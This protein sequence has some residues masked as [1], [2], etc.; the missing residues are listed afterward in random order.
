MIS[1]QQAS[2]R[3]ENAVMAQEETDKTYRRQENPTVITEQLL[4]N[5]S[6]N[7]E[8]SCH[9]DESNGCEGPTHCDDHGALVLHCE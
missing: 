7:E 6:S 4:M 9:E 8:S 2:P 5:C 3:T 1:D